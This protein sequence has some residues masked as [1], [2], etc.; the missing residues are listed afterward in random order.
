MQFLTLYLVSVPIFVL[1]DLLW[2][3]VLARDFYQTRLAALLGPV[4]WSAA[5]CFYLIFIAGLTYFA[6]MPGVAS[7]SLLRTALLG[8]G[9]G[10][11]A[12]ATYDLT[13]LATL[14]D[15]P[16]GLKVVD[17]AWGAVLGAAVASGAHVLVRTLPL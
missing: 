6:T 3:G 9:F 13:N 16:L 17:M 1:L 11:V 5:V 12:Y 14:R 8:A 7:G 2:L 4:Q 10:F 15:W